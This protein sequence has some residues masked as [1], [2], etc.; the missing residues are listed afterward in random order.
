MDFR[1]RVANNAHEVGSEH[2]THSKSLNRFARLRSHGLRAALSWAGLLVSALFAYLAVRNVRFGD[3]WDGLRTSNYWW[4]APAFAL[5]VATVYVKALRW[6]YLFAPETRPRTK[7]VVNS[8]LIGYFF[9]NILPARAGEAARVLALKRQG[10]T[11]RAEAA[12]T[13]VIERAYDVLVLLALLFIS[14]PWLPHVT[15]LRAAG[16]LA[17]VLAACVV[18]A[19]VVFAVFGLRPLQYVLR[20]LG[21]LP[22]LSQERVAHIGDN[23]GQGLAALR[24]PRL[25]LGALFWTTLGWLALAASVWFVIRGFHLHL[26]F[27]AALLVVVATNLAAIL[28]SSPAGIGVFEAAV[29]VALRPYDVPHAQAL[30]CALVIH[31][32]NFVPFVAAGLFL[33]R[34]TLRLSDVKAEERSLAR[35]NAP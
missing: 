30:S 19:I 2:T 34:G 17:V 15:W 6:R 8:L 31:V 14:V 5:L 13:V 10:G 35:V 16:V 24:R 4:L 21:R 23:L 33:L 22:F 32:L 20:P 3:V 18:V 27:V 1:R 12:A 28:P 25:V 9:N 7:A 29:I 11:S 26:S